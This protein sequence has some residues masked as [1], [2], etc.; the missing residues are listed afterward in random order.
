MAARK[1]YFGY[2]YQQLSR[3][4]ICE[5]GFPWRHTRVGQNV[6]ILIRED[7]TETETLYN[8]WLLQPSEPAQGS[9]QPITIQSLCQ[10]LL[11]PDRRAELIDQIQA[12]GATGHQDQWVIASNKPIPTLHTE[13]R[14][15]RNDFA[16]AI[17]E[18]AAQAASTTAN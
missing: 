1:P 15:D 3:G 6:A 8:G 18:P 16:T 13:L 10:V 2:T 11:N 7:E 14:F 17:Q 5:S 4:E 12:Q 9:N